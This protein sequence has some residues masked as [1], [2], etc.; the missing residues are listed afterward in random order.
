VGRLRPVR[1]VR[2]GAGLSLAVEFLVL[3]LRW[4]GVDVPLG[5]GEVLAQLLGWGAAYL[6]PER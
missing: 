4:A 6:V 2:V 1:K 5:W 3:N